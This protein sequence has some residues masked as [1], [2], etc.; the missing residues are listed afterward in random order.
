MTGF[1]AFEHGGNIYA[2]AGELGLSPE[3]VLDFSANINPLGLPPGLKEHLTSLLDGIVH[4]PEPEAAQLRAALA[5]SHGCAAENLIVGN[6]A[7]E[8]LYLLCYA[9][10]PKRVLV[11]APTFSEYEKAARAAG[12]DISYLPL[13]AADGFA[14][15]WDSLQAALAAAD[16]FFL[17][18]PNN[19]TGTLLKREDVLRLAAEAAKEQCFLLVDESFQD[20]LPAQEQYSILADLPQLGVSAAV[21]RSL[22]KFY[23]IPGLRLGF[24]AGDTALLQELTAK[25]DTWNVNLLAQQA[26]L[27]ALRCKD[28]QQES[29]SYVAKAKQELHAAL[30]ALP[31]VHAYE[32]AVNYILLDMQQTGLNSGQWR[33]C[34]KRRG[35]LVRDC[36]NYVGLGDSHIRV[37]VRRQDENER[38]VAALTAELTK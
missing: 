13:V 18:N 32:P 29:R 10:K 16:I 24:M 20:F 22:T 27:W 2:A 14:L 25:K 5:A 36:A 21:L 28:Y 37:A 23:A 34:L 3:A 7:A 30:A 1:A 15:P 11:T 9:R 17:C 31:G 38:L 19:P 26:G 35:I 33:E 4:Y 6:G 12:A 8:L